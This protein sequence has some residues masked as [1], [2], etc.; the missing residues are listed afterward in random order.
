MDAEAAITH[1]RSPEMIRE[2]CRMVYDA[3]QAD[4]L[5][6]FRLVPER[7]PEAVKTVVAEIRK[8]YPELDIP[9]HS[10][11]R[12]FVVDGVDHATPVLRPRAETD[13]RE[14]LRVQFELA[15]TSV[16]LDA[17]AGADWRFQNPLDRRTH[18]RSEGLALASFYLFAD[19]AFSSNP[20]RPFQADA[21]GLR[22]FRTEKLAEGF[23]VTDDNPL[24]GL[25][26][27]AELLRKL[28]E[29]LTTRPSQFGGAPARIGDL[30]DWFWGE[31]TP[32]ED[33]SHSLPAA[34]ILRALL[35]CFSRIWP[36]RLEMDGQPLGDVWRH[37]VVQA[38]GLTDGLI[39]FHKLS[40][41]LAYSLVEPLEE[42]G[43]RIVDLDALTGLPEY[44]N[45][46][47]FVDLG[48]LE[49][50]HSEVLKST[51]AVDSEVIVE[52]RALTVCLLDEIAQGVRAELKRTPEALPL[53]R[54]LQGG[55]WSAG[56]ALA[57]TKRP[58]GAPPIQIA[59]DGTVF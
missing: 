16:L 37:P 32:N 58:D 43:L 21:E 15:V 31:A 53:S 23:Q 35:D 57:H 44:R 36:S 2:R 3:A 46:G 34:A 39:P 27:R 4:R 33:G 25:E 5:E 12:H 40:Q 55:T 47:L 30:A 14:R 50:K 9:H 51:H 52:W 49:P 28:G 7:L 22:N 45:G 56:R 26:A 6:H 38:D 42:S 1:L 10:R 19:G 13:A 17:G 20:G 11:W 48:V 59:S 54:I 29:G 18:G 24:V 41:W 8:N